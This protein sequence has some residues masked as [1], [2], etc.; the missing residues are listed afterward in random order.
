MVSAALTAFLTGIT[1]PIE[2]AFLF[3][4]PVL[5]VI[6]AL[7]AGAAY[8]VC[9]A[10]R[11]QTR[12]HLFPRA[13]RLRR[14]LPASSQCPL[15][16]AIGPVWVLSISGVFSFAIRQFNLL[17]PGR[18]AES[19]S[20]LAARSSGGDEFS[21]CRSSARSA[22]RSNIVRPR[23]VHHAPAREAEGPRQGQCAKS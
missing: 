5:Y 10:A 15:A 19:E 22:G 1:E 12:V 2:F 4:A 23:C 8:F 21:L 9:I 11:D 13:H 18:E 14:A 7:L 6:H 16:S 17:T 20:T 3:V